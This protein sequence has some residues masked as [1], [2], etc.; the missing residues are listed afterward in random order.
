MSTELG[1]AYVQIVPSA[2]GIGKSISNEIIPESKKAGQSAGIGIASAIKKAIIVA[3]IGKAIVSTI[4]EGGK[5]EQSLGGIETLFKDNAN[6]V[7]KYAKEAFKTTGLSANQ[8]MEN[9]TGFSASLLQSLGG[10]TEK[11]A[12]IANTAMIDMA[13]NSN[14]MGTS[15][16]S[17]QNAYQG[18]AKQ[19]YT[20]LDNLKLGYSGT[21]TEMQRLLKDAEKIT[22]I[23]YDISNLS[24][25]YSAIH[26]IQTE[27]DITGTTAKEASTTII[28]SWSA[29]ASSFKNV[30]GALALGEGL[31]ESMQGLGE[32]LS[33]FLFQNLLPM[34]GNIISQIPSLI[35]TFWQSA[36]P[37]F[38]MMGGNLL[39]KLKEGL[40]NSI[41]LFLTKL[42]EFIIQ[43]KAWIDTN[44][45][46]FISSGV[47]WVVNLSKGL[48]QGLPHII[49]TMSVIVSNI[50]ETILNAVPKIL[51][52]GFNLIK[53]LAKGFMNNLPAVKT[54]IGDILSKVITL[55][56]EKGPDIL[57]K[58]IDLITH[59]AKGIFNNL[60]AVVSAMGDI[61]KRIVSLI[62]EN[63]PTILK[64]GALLIKKLALGMLS[65]VGTAVSA[66]GKILLN[67]IKAIATKISEFFKKGS[68]SIKSFAKGMLRAIPE[69]LAVIPRLISGLLGK[70]K[71]S[72][73]SFVDVGKNLIKGLWKGMSN[74]KDWLM[75]KIGGFTESIVSHFKSFF[76][77]HSP[78]R[79]FAEI[80]EFLNLGLAKGITDNIDLVTKAMDKLGLAA[81]KE[82]ET[83]GYL[84]IKSKLDEQM[85]QLDISSRNMKKDEST[86]LGA[87]L[88]AILDVL[89]NLSEDLPN[90]FEKSV[91][92]LKLEINNREFGR[93]VKSL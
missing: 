68:D 74:V 43:I 42:N 41:P 50:L 70:L 33:I 80:G 9:V 13:D 26:V 87:T 36:I 63:M 39:L 86:N 66:I 34:L 16:E 92:K 71:G 32:T 46:T 90:D 62:I 11:A 2:R 15:M 78:S 57:A 29:M 25:V 93:M 10:D 84:S 30:L 3:G 12:E 18:F 5:L 38:T 14:K 21:K 79:V 8:Y 60:P 44:L 20:M 73:S 27:L 35:I 59:F 58:G 52:G 1:K 76:G 22:G 82:F 53:G 69:A 67:I 83:E 37:H 88:D 17:I 51:E 72:L 65:V 48:L 24:D 64:N 85:A 55:I 56:I 54:A 81:E 6:Q 40:V 23:K 91:S 7:K 4:Q 28:G 31:Q 19:N 77:I 45:S 75:K 47:N 89:T 49:S 61:L